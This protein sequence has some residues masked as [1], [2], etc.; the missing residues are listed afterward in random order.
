VSAAKPYSSFNSRTPATR[1]AVEAD[2]ERERGGVD[3]P[4]I[5]ALDADGAAHRRTE[6]VRAGGLPVL[7]LV[8]GAE[9]AVGQF[10]AGEPPTEFACRG[11]DPRDDHRRRRAEPRTQRDVALDD[12]VEAGVWRVGGVAR[13]LDRGVDVAGRRLD[14][15]LGDVDVRSVVGRA[16]VLDGEAVEAQVLRADADVVVRPRVDGDPRPAL[17]GAGHRGLAVDD[18]VLPEEVHL[19]RGARNGHVPGWSPA[20]K[21]GV[22]CPCRG[23]SSV[24]SE[25]A[26]GRLV[27]RQSVNS[28][29]EI[30]RPGRVGGSRRSRA[31]RRTARTPAE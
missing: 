15:R 24:D 17:D 27:A 20:Y 14:Q 30:S 13:L 2:D 18:G 9:G 19:A 28:E 6:R 4:A 1:P 10:F 16:G 5:V 8:L 11:V 23:W 7:H 26:V 21:K 12:D 31:T 29:S 22:R 25:S 3:S